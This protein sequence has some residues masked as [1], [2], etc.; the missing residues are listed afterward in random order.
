MSELVDWKTAAANICDAMQERATQVATR[1]SEDLYEHMMLSVQ[2]YLR[3]NV[4][5][6]LSSEIL[7]KNSEIA[8]LK[9]EKANR[10]AL[11]NEAEEALEKCERALTQVS[12]VVVV[13]EELR[14]ARAILS[15]IKAAQASEDK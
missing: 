5:F 15:K 10:D 2:D 13:N 1:A 12:G 3:D 14:R 4:R 6:N 8:R 11:F 9:D 7:G